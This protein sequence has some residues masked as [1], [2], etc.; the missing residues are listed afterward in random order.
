M[1]GILEGRVAIVTGAGRG[2]G[3]AIASRFASEGAKVVVTARSEGQ[4]RETVDQIRAA[5]GTADMMPG[6]CTE[7]KDVEAVVAFARERFGTVTALVSNAGVSGPFGPIWY[8][9]PDAWWYAQSVHVRG[10]LLF[11][12]AVLPGMMEQKTGR[13][14]TVSALASTRVE[15]SMSAYAVAKSTQVRITQHLALESGEH[16]I[17][18]FAIEPGTVFTDLSKGTMA[19]PDAQRWKPGMIE[20]IGK[21]EAQAD[22]PA[23]LAKCANLCLRLASGE[24]D[25]LSGQYI[26]VREDLDEKLR[27]AASAKKG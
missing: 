6:D 9:D 3:R 10:M 7:R 19:D 2:F 14:V 8:V 12:R 24:C 15:H 25:S 17:S 23:G 27:Q 18:A 20:H 4:L 1:A 21:P 22:A 16:G 11:V 5:G 13:I 26:D